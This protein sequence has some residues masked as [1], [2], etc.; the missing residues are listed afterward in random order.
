MVHFRP[1]PTRSVSRGHARVIEPA[2]IQVLHSTVRKRGPAQAWK[3]INE[4][5]EFDS[6]F[7]ISAQHVILSVITPSFER[8]MLR[9]VA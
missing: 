3:R 7:A 8:E 4:L 1:A 9:R 2:L 6:H 5:I